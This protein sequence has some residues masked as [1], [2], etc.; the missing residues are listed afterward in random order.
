MNMNAPPKSIP[1]TSKRQIQ[2]GTG[3]VMSTSSQSSYS[4]SWKNSPPV[5]LILG[6]DTPLV[7][8]ETFDKSALLAPESFLLSGSSGRVRDLMLFVLFRVSRL[9]LSSEF[10][11]FSTLFESS[12]LFVSPFLELSTVI[13]SVSLSKFLLIQELSLSLDSKSSWLDIVK[14]KTSSVVRLSTRLCIRGDLPPMLTLSRN[15]KDCLGPSFEA[16]GARMLVRHFRLT[17]FLLLHIAQNTR[18]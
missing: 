12:S 18:Q 2:R 15:F 11:P 4:N 5:V 1:K 8:V 3:F 7:G 17:F 9:N 6:V 13:I 10:S 14:L 16:G